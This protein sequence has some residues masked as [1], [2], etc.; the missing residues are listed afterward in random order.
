MTIQ[1]EARNAT[2]AD[3]AALLKDQQGRKVDVVA[4]AAAITA[5]DGQIVIKGT[6]PV[7]TPDGFDMA[8]GTYRPTAVF[9]EGVADKLDIPLRYLRR[10][11]ETRPD[12]YDVN[13]NG[14]LHGRK[15]VLRRPA[16]DSADAEIVRP[17]IAGDGRS[18][19]V[20]AFRGDD[21]TGVARALLSNGYRVLDNLDAL[22]AALAGV[23]QAGVAVDIDSCDLS[24]RRMS[25]KV[26]CPEIRAL[27]PSLLRSYRSPWN[28]ASGA[29]NPTVFAGFV[30]SNSET[31]NGS[32]SVT[33]RLVFQV[34]KNGLTITKDAFRGVH[35]GS[36]MDDGIVKWSDETRAKEVELMTLKTA[37]VIR[38]TLDV[39][40][41]EKVI[42]GVEEKAGVRLE[43][44]AD[45]V[46]IV[47]K[48]LQFSD[49]VSDR[50]LDLFIQSGDITAGGV[51]QA[52]TAAA[53]VVEDPDTAADMEGKALQALELAAAL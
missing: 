13:L 5:R 22:T 28:G 26:I 34:C 21:G 48:R 51:M 33:P 36:R 7:L 18:F 41:V 6:E 4:P 47:T 12:L 43:K 17:G 16:F 20:R 1:T 50:I 29:D 35:I 27:A 46:A 38:T 32:W 45:Q 15:P 8:D 24:E 11:R 53:Q 37:D 25:V 40:Y 14:W 39:E 23:E 19:L 52:V 9:D 49:A 44:A 42:A 30:I 3:L 10:L 31:G 2:L